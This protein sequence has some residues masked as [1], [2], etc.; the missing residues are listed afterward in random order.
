FVI[1]GFLA[2]RASYAFNKLTHAVIDTAI[3][4]STLTD[5]DYI[6]SIATLATL[7]SNPQDI[8][9]LLDN[10]RHITSGLSPGRP[11]RNADKQQLLATYVQLETHFTS[12]QDPARIFTPNELREQLSPA[13]VALLPKPHTEKI[14]GHREA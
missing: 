11:I 4:V 8:D 12:G 14:A 13:F 1:A 3:G 5:R 7:S 10:M 9:V 2:L 6:E